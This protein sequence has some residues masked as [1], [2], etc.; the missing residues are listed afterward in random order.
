MGDPTAREVVNRHQARGVRIGRLTENDA[1]QNAEEHGVGGHP[2]SEGEQRDGDE[3]GRSQKL[4]ER[5]ADVDHGWRV[6]KGSGGQR[7]ART[8][9]LIQYPSP[10]FVYKRRW[11]VGLG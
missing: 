5:V 10:S 7:L 8:E 1:I 3:P 2:Q 9:R 6:S 11:K 4:S